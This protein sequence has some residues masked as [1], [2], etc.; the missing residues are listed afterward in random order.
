MIYAIYSISLGLSFFICRIGT[1][2]TFWE[3]TGMSS[4]LD[5][6]SLKEQGGNLKLR[7]SNPFILR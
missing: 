2:T 3:R 7:Q 1:K 5:R 6:L 4:T